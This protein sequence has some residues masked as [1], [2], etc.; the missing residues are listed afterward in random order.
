[1]CS[2]SL[3]LD[4]LH[5]IATSLSGSD[6]KDPGLSV[7]VCAFGDILFMDVRV[8]VSLSLLSSSVYTYVDNSEDVQEIDKIRSSSILRYRP[9]V[10][11]HRHGTEAGKCNALLLIGF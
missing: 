7:R 6:G 8:D 10:S 9:Q 5:L 4:A 11:S 2:F 1:M 3:L